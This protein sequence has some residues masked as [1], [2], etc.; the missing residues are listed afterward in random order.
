M[1]SSTFIQRWTSVNDLTTATTTNS[2]NKK[3]STPFFLRST[4]A[5]LSPPLL[6][7]LKLSQSS[8]SL[9]ES[10]SAHLKIQCQLYENRVFSSRVANIIRQFE[11]QAAA[12]MN[13]HSKISSPIRSVFVKQWKGSKTN[14]NS[15]RTPPIV[16]VETA[17]PKTFSSKKNNNTNKPQP[18]IICEKIA[19]HNRPTPPPVS[20]KNTFTKTWSQLKQV[21]QHQQ[22]K[23]EHIESD[24]DC[25]THRISSVINNGNNGS[26]TLSRSSTTA[27]TDSTC[28]SSCSSSSNTP[29]PPGFAR[30][31]IAST[32]KQRQ[33]ISNVTSFK[34]ANSPFPPITTFTRTIPSIPLTILPLCPINE[35]LEQQQPQQQ[36]QTSILKNRFCSADVILIDPYCQLSNT[37]II[38][39]ETSVSQS[40]ITEIITIN[41]NLP[42]KYKR[43]SLIRLYGSDVIQQHGH[44]PYHDVVLED[45]VDPPFSP[46]IV[47]VKKNKL[48]TDE[49]ELMEILGRG[50]FGEVKK[51]REKSTQH[52]LAAKFIQ[53]NK[54][55]DRIEA[56][57]E[58]EI[59]K[60]LQ[61]PRLLQLYDAFETKG[62]FCLVMEL[63]SGGELFERVIDDD[64][65][66]T[67]RLC[68]LYMM[69]ICE[70]V[71]FMHSSNIIHL[72]MKPENILCVN[73]NGH[74]IKIIDFGLARKFDPSKQ[75]K[76][77]FGTPEFVAPEVIN[78]DRVGFGTDMWSVGVI[79]YVLLSGLSPFMGENDNDT[80][81]NINRANYDFD[82][83]SFTD[84]SKEAKDFISKLLVKDK[85][86]RLSARQCLAHPWLTRRPK[87]VSIPSDEETAEKKLS[88]K[89][90][91][92]FVIRRRWQKAVNALLALQRMGMTL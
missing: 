69:Q 45:D 76:V 40:S 11:S 70:G 82:D 30:P 55:Q 41:T 13:N 87:L 60:A 64:F 50:K 32:Q 21:S 44:H 42:L 63:I 39:S 61:H 10:T 88:T 8:I 57:N 46:R 59:M 22:Q 6:S 54:E 34:R 17:S 48:V 51:C 68:E 75:L 3:L 9:V 20:P 27:T 81:A 49:Y 7:N 85:D 91:R 86:K 43:D 52:Y 66:L 65:I 80:Y 56:L 74:R 90:L 47:A 53:I 89:K 16:V 83:E 37:D 36:T 5:P 33:F 25:A 1:S 24:T 29:S 19:N 73:R 4:P 62:T 79:C 12:S 92:R 35:D 2:H 28:S 14:E 58:I 72:D 26:V 77:L 78:F 15:S 23:I 31:T 18:I 67:E 71:C 38:L 84:I